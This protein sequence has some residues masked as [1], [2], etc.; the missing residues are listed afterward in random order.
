L[1]AFTTYISCNADVLCGSRNFVNFINV[2]NAALRPFDVKVTCLQKLEKDV[3]DIFSDISGFSE[4]CG[5][6]NGKWDVEYA[7][8][9][10]RE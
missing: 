4:S 8:E 1:Y 6:C 10:F 9:C 2:N 7:G 5:V 3:F